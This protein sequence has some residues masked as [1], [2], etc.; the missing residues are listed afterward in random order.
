MNPESSRRPH[1]DI[2]QQ[3]VQ[4]LVETLCAEIR[5]TEGAYVNQI[6]EAISLFHQIV[7]ALKQHQPPHAILPAI[8]TVGQIVKNCL[9]GPSLYPLQVEGWPD[10]LSDKFAPQRLAAAL[11]VSELFCTRLEDFDSASVIEE[12]VGNVFYRL[13]TTPR[14]LQQ[15]AVVEL[16][17]FCRT[18]PR[19]VDDS[20]SILQRLENASGPLSEPTLLFPD[21]MLFHSI[22]LSGF[23]SA[24]TTAII[25]N[26][27]PA[28]V[29][30]DLI[31]A[32]VSLP[33]SELRRRLIEKL[34]LL[35]QNGR[36]E[37]LSGDRRLAHP[38][39]RPAAIGAIK[40]LGS[41]GHYEID[42]PETVHKFYAVQ[43]P[44]RRAEWVYIGQRLKAINGMHDIFARGEELYRYLTQV[45][46][47]CVAQPFFEK[48]E[49]F[50]NQCTLGRPQGAEYSTFFSEEYGV[51]NPPAPVDTPVFAIARE[52]SL[53]T[54][55]TS[56]YIRDSINR[57]KGYARGAKW[58][59]EEIA[60]EAGARVQRFHVADIEKYPGPG[61]RISGLDLRRALDL[62]SEKTRAYY[63]E[64]CPW[65]RNGLRA[66][67]HADIFHMRGFIAITPTFEPGSDLPSNS[68]RRGSILGK[69]YVFVWFND[70]FHN[71]HG[72]E[73]RTWLIPASVFERKCIFAIENPGI[74]V[75]LLDLTPEGFLKE[76]EA[77]KLPILSVSTASVLWGGLANAWPQGQGPV[78]SWETATHSWRNTKWQDPFHIHRALFDGSYSKEATP[79][80]ERLFNLTFQE[81][82]RIQAV[83][84][85]GHDL[86]NSWL[87]IEE[88]VAKG[89]LRRGE[90]P[91]KLTLPRSPKNTPPTQPPPNGANTVGESQSAGDE[92]GRPPEAPYGNQSF[93][94]ELSYTQPRTFL[95]ERFL[96]QRNDLLRNGAEP[97]PESFPRLQLDYTRLFRQQRDTP[98]ITGHDMMLY[99][100]EGE[101][102]PLVRGGARD[103][104]ITRRVVMD[105]YM[106]ALYE[107]HIVKR[108]QTNNCPRIVLP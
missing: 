80:I 34:H 64:A 76:A 8:Q 57:R 46:E 61:C 82:Q 47:M 51:D 38:L 88:Q 49:E 83:M 103:A 90:P 28:Q 86:Y 48:T 106:E 17:A 2:T 70:H 45:V 1:P 91:P 14:P 52:D 27:M 4:K 16:Q 104:V 21:E 31:K 39:G 62:E 22:D 63:K 12:L 67:H 65:I 32:S 108:F 77:Q 29:A 72:P 7:S 24:F 54:L 94:N 74:D 81:H 105:E 101:P 50:F 78:H 30:T 75:N 98:F 56:A 15:S 10:A 43:A 23:T 92:S 97:L 66:L 36:V 107:Q 35:L 5:H 60:E 84:R 102:I 41:E 19:L 55:R 42:D 69:P 25:E 9:Q 18:A 53:Q 6:P 71:L 37:L 33:Q 99:V 44:S 68:W 96:K 79:E 11:A 59:I 3:Q 100:P 58:L 13:I 20:I 95:L 93:V 73:I 40:S 26:E 89:F 87:T 85:F